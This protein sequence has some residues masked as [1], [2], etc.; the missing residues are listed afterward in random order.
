MASSVYGMV[1]RRDLTSFGGFLRSTFSQTLKQNMN[2]IAIREYV[3][4]ETEEGIEYEI[5]NYCYVTNE[6]LS[7]WKTHKTYGQ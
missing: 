7:P 3:T 5:R 1:T 2:I 4:K 6:R